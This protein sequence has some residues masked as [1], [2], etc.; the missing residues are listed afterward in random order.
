MAVLN[1]KLLRDAL[2]LPVDL[3]TALVDKLLESLNVPLKEDIERAWAEEV[4]KRRKEIESGTVK[5]IPGEEV[6]KK[7]RARYQK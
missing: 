2:S 4:E 1:E 7:I 6:F 3:R 5:T